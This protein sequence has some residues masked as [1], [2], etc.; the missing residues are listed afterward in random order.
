MTERGYQQG[1]GDWMREQRDGLG[2]KQSDVAEQLGVSPR[3]VHNWESGKASMTAYTERRIRTL[4]KQAHE[5]HNA[6]QRKQVT[7]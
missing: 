5:Q 4:F 2:L 3:S 1:F 7:V 6:A